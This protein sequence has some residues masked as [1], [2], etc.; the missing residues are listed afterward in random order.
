MKRS[1]IVLERK[2]FIIYEALSAFL[3]LPSP[4]ISIPLVFFTLGRLSGAC[5]S[6]LVSPERSREETS[7]C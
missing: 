5:S 4:G 6:V 2:S 1:I 7:D 3:S